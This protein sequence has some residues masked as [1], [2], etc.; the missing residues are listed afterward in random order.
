MEA[1]CGSLWS[2]PVAER[3]MAQTLEPG[4]KSGQIQVVS[5]RWPNRLLTIM[6]SCSVVAIKRAPSFPSAKTNP[7]TSSKIH[8]HHGHLPAGRAR[9]RRTSWLNSTASRS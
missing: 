2:S 8:G 5:S 6:P 4:L 9:V 3:T 1:R 7:M